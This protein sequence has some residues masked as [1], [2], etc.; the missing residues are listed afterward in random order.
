[1]NRKI[2]VAGN[3]KMNLEYAPGMKLL[4]ALAK[5]V[6]SSRGMEVLICPPYLYIPSM[7]EQLRHE[8]H[9]ISLG[10]QNCHMKTHGAYTGEVS[11]K[12]LASVGAKYVIIGHS[13]RREQFGESGALLQQKVDAALDANLHVIFCV[14]ETLSMREAGREQEIVRKQ[15]AEGISQVPLEK[16]IYVTLAYEPV[17]AI[18]T[19]VTAT[20]AQAQEMHAFMRSEIAK[21]FDEAV[22]ERTTLLYGGSVKPGNAHTIFSQKDVDGGLIG[23]ASLDE[24]QFIAIVRSAQSNL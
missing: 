3:W 24:H 20:P 9:D 11:A 5:Q 13:E 23:G 14:G 2:I 16:M 15:I 12:M 10:G 1:M 7:V 21:L 4:S 8:N 18:G 22:A 17:W 6:S 19:G